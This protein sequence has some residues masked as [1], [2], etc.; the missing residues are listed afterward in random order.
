MRIRPT[1]P[2]RRQ[3]NE[4]QI[5]SQLLL[6]N[7]SETFKYSRPLPKSME[8]RRPNKGKKPGTPN[9]FTDKETASLKSLDT[10]EK[11]QELLDGIEYHGGRRLSIAEVFRLRRGDCIECAC[12]ASYIFRLNKIDSFLMDLYSYKYADHV[13]C[14]YK[15]KGYYG[16][17]AHSYYAGLRNRSPVYKTLRELTMSYFEHFFEFNG[18]YSLKRY[19]VPV[20]LPRKE[21]DWVFSRQFM[22]DFEVRINSV[23]HKNVIPKYF[24]IPKVNKI[25]FKNEFVELPRDARISEEYKDAAKDIPRKDYPR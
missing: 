1:G 9:G 10:P 14:V 16:S 21:G 4:S 2:M 7:Y 11:I 13:I 24:R 15:K 5:L 22:Y 8:K 12:L 25:S 3:R 20:R 17:V 19:S 23:R 6:Y 18:V